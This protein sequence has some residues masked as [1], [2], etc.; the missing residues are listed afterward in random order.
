MAEGRSNGAIAQQLVVS[1]GAVEKHVRNIFTK[2]DLAAGRTGPPPRARGAALAGGPHEQSDLPGPHRVDGCRQR[3][4]DRGAA[5]RHVHRH[6]PDGLRSHHHARRDRRDGHC[7]DHHHRAAQRS[8][9]CPLRRERNRPDRRRCQ[10]HLRAPE[11]E[12]RNA[13]RWRHP[14][15]EQR[16]FGVVEH[17]V[18]CLVHDRRTCRRGRARAPAAAACASR[19]STATSTRRRRAAASA[20]SVPAATSTWTRVAAASV[21]T[22]CTR[23][24]STSARRA[25]ACACR[26]P[27]HRPRCASGSSGGG[28]TIEVPPGYAFNIDAHSSGG[29][30]DVS[31]VAHDPGS[32]RTI[33][34]DSSG[35][36][37]TIR[38]RAD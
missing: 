23:R 18:R 13:G 7:R 37:V 26:S 14:L 19:A 36:G 17:V 15:R 11:A 21:A 2:L 8:G 16:M 22:T 9:V 32:S 5:V 25:A 3:L 6:R 24:W 27:I 1:D 35:G 38:Y 28:V 31:G 10:G 20:S 34:A 4:R 29:G 12:E 30:V 33:T